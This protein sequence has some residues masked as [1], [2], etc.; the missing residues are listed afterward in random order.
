MGGFAATLYYVLRAI[1]SHHHVRSHLGGD[2]PVEKVVA[3]LRGI[4]EDGT[5]TI[6]AV[7]SSPQH[8]HP[9]A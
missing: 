8:Y 6:Y 9:S 7:R 2:T 5:G 4:C 1:Y 3:T